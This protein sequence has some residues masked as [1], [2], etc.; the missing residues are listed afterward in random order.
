MQQ[1][2]FDEERDILNKLM[3]D[4][5]PVTTPAELKRTTQ[6]YQQLRHYLN[7]I[8]IL[9]SDINEFYY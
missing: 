1:I 8:N 2:V 4:I 9:Q 7:N 6:V 3:S 5:K